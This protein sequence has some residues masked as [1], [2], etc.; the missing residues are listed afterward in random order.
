[1]HCPYRHHI[2]IKPAF[3]APPAPLRRRTG[4][5]RRPES[6]KQQLNMPRDG[7]SHLIPAVDRL[8][9]LLVVM[10]SGCELLLATVGLTAATIDSAKT[11]GVRK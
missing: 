5:L 6:V 11:V 8:L 10:G 2:R 1:M 4:P 7:C 3:R 9:L